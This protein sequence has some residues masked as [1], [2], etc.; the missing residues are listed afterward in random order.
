MDS[1]NA[2]NSSSLYCIYRG[3]RSSCM[4]AMS[5]TKPRMDKTTLA[6]NR[7][8]CVFHSFSS[9]SVGCNV[10]PHA[11]AA[12]KMLLNPTH[13]SSKL[14]Q[15]L[16]QRCSTSSFQEETCPVKSIRILEHFDYTADWRFKT[17]SYTFCLHLLFQCL[18]KTI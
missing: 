14:Q 2:V 7:A 18:L 1:L 11:T 4:P 6:M 3:S 9:Y 10:Q 17:W 12:M 13:L 16:P 5:L 15:S 8:F